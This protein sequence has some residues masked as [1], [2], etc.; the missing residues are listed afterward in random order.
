MKKET[1]EVRNKY[2]KDLNTLEDKNVEL[3]K[4][5]E[6]YKRDNSSWNTFKN[7]VNKD[8]SSIEKSIMEMSN[9]N[10]NKTK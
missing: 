3:R 6:E 2:E 5:I 7:N 1:Q 10:M 8:I 4:T 9:R